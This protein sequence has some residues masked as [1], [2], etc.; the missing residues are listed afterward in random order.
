M[1][2]TAI[3]LHL[4]NLYISQPWLMTLEGRSKSRCQGRWKEL[5]V[6]MGL[7]GRRPHSMCQAFLGDLGIHETGCGSFSA[8]CGASKTGIGC[9]S[10]LADGT[11]T[12]DGN[13]M[14]ACLAIRF[15]F[16]SCRCSIKTFQN[17][18]CHL[19]HLAF[20]LSLWPICGFW[21]GFCWVQT[22]KKWSN[23][24]SL[25]YRTPRPDNHEKNQ[26]QMLRWLRCCHVFVG[27]CLRVSVV[28]YW[29]RAFHFKIVSKNGPRCGWGP[30]TNKPDKHYQPLAPTSFGR[31]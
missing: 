16:S 15:F 30:I 3:N 10:L 6:L 25:E 21:A 22:E 28:W 2:F 12:I 5:P 7:A 1:I 17:S 13:N 8:T 19:I 23:L 20:Q 18:P 14:S 27:I 26:G 31:A 29:E 9:C 4:I 11:S 24:W